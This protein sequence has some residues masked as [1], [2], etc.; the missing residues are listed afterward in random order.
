MK[1]LIADDDFTSRRILETVLGKLGYEVLSVADGDEAW[2]KLQEKDGPKLAILDWVMPGIEGVEICR[3][4]RKI[5]KDVDQYTYVILLTS[6]GSKENI[7]IGMEAGADDYIVKP[8][9]YHELRVRVRAGQ[10]IIELQSELLAAKQEMSLQSRTDPLT[11]ILNRRAIL[12]QIE[13]ELSRAKR[14]GK[15]ISLSLLDIDYFKK[16]NDTYGHAAG[17]IVLRECV[18]RI[19]A[20]I[21]IY[22]SLGRFGGEEFLIIIPGAEINEGVTVC[23]RI[24]SAIGDTSFSAGGYNMRITVS[25]GIVAWDNKTD[26]ETLIAAADKA[27]YQAKDNGRNRIEQAPPLNETARLSAA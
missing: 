23:E 12:A 5:E 4:L 3:K 10:R 9:D 22:D 2:E 26:A 20:A 27:L 19:K 24:R 6:K 11:G 13:T 25:Q 17:D 16:V 7:V 8:F 15:K 18:E 14:D 1:I 21:R